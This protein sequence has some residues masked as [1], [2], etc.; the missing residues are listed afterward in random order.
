MHVDTA[1]D[2]LATR[3][4]LDATWTFVTRVTGKVLDGPFATTAR[5]LR[6]EV[7]IELG[8]LQSTTKLEALRGSMQCGKRVLDGPSATEVT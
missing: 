3:T 1:T 4:L 6:R 2:R 5:W 8:L 7:Q